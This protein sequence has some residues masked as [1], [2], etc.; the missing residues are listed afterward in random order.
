MASISRSIAPLRESGMVELVE[1]VGASADFHRAVEGNDVLAAT[2]IPAP[3]G[4]SG[5]EVLV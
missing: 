5:L 3:G 2:Q 1:A 4:D